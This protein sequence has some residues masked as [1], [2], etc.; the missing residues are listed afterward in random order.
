MISGV[1]VVPLSS[2]FIIPACSDLAWKSKNQ[3]QAIKQIDRFLSDQCEKPHTHTPM[4]THTHWCTHT[5]NTHW[6]THTHE[7]HMK[8][9]HHNHTRRHAGTLCQ[10]EREREREKENAETN[11]RPFEGLCWLQTGQM[12]S[13]IKS[14]KKANC[15]FGHFWAQ[16]LKNKWL[17]K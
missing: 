10:W 15:A 14:C 6:C 13:E 16:K 9:T 17:F 8:H 5:W 7:T 1:R 3:A 12:L 11:Q 2:I 4:H